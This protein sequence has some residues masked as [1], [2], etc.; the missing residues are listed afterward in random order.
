M[1]RAGAR[2]ERTAV[3]HNWADAAA[4]RPVPA[5]ENPFRREHGLAGK[6]VVL[7]SGNAG[8]AHTFH[9]VQEAM[10]RLRE[11]PGILFLFIGGG[12]RMAEIRAAAER[13][14]VEN[15]RFMGYVPRE[16]LIYSL[17]AADASLV[18]ESP[19][20]P[21]LLVPSKTYGILASGRPLVF[22]GAER[23][24]VAAVVRAARCGVVVPA[25]DA[26]G[27]VAALSALKNDPAMAAE[28]GARGRIAAEA[29]YDRRHATARWAATV[30]HLMEAGAAVERR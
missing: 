4:V 17:S 8:R 6:F 11:D 27:L 13:D 2:E 29:V 30:E 23:S 28:M 10:R 21:G 18:T 3:V 12:H 20:V 25:D 16:D 9:A 1:V 7:Y 26:A 22:V 24:D 5:D 19:D 15:A 14:G